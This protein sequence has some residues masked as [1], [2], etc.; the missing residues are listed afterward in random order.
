MLLDLSR[1]VFWSIFMLKFRH[2]VAL[3]LLTFFI[4]TCSNP[5]TQTN[6][7]YTIGVFQVLP[8]PPP[9]EVR[10]GFIQ[11]LADGGYK[12][13]EKVKFEIKDA[14]GEI[15]NLSLIAK[16]FVGDRVNMIFAIGTPPLQAAVKV[17]PPELPVVFAYASDPWG[18]GAG[19]TP[20]D[21]L[22]NVTGT[23]GTNPLEAEIDLIQEVLPQAK[24]IGLIYNPGEPNS[25]YEAKLFKDIA[26]KKG[27]TVVEQSVSNSAE[28]LQAAESLATKDIQAFGKIGDYATVAGF[29]A[30]TKV[31]FANK[32]PVFSV[33]QGDIDAGALAVIGWSYFDDGY[34]AGELALEVIKGKSPANMPFVPL[35]KKVLLISQKSAKLYGVT[36]PDAVLKKAD[37]VLPE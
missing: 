30:I 26:T 32:I 27:L 31:G 18:A 8:A 24:R 22:P 21:H 12:D 2:F 10:R 7:L 13:G 9:D 28:V 4:A 19:K 29:N 17:A 16:K 11:A 1:V 5:S 23:I 36:V 20:T 35:T 34:R 6:N 33:D 25:S 3:F 15:N 14:Q 37:K